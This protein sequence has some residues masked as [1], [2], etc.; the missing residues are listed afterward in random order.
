M[1]AVG[2]GSELEFYWATDGSS[3]WTAE[4][5]RVH[6]SARARAARR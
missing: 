3:T 2:P 6:E 4:K 5:G 1:R